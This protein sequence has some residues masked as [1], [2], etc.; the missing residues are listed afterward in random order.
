M[1]VFIV[2]EG[3]QNTGYGHLTRCL[4]IYEAFEE[5][6]IQPT[7][8]ANCDEDG[9]KYLGNINLVFYN[10]FENSNKFL[11]QIKGSDITVIDS[12][13]ASKD[14]YVQ[15]S[16]SVKKAV[17]IDDYLRIEYPKG[18]IVNGAIDAENLPYNRKPDQKY[19]LGIDYIPLRKKISL[20]SI[21]FWY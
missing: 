13:I 9:K 16:E 7:L 21:L 12:Y 4:A 5:L 2:V 11:K 20:Y 6:D 8:I 17:Y 3:F 19:L 10:W 14:I 18:I 15:V 1:K